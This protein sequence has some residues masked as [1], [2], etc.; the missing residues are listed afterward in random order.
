MPTRVAARDATSK[1]RA[2]AYS[3]SVLCRD[4]DA[5]GRRCLD[6]IPGPLQSD[7]AARAHYLNCMIEARGGRPFL[8]A[9][10]PAIEV[11]RQCRNLTA[12]RRIGRDSCNI[13]DELSARA[14][15][16]CLL[17]LATERFGEGKQQIIEFHSKEVAGN[18]RGV[19]VEQGGFTSGRRRVAAPFWHRSRKPAATN[20]RLPQK[21]IFQR[22]SDQPTSCPA[23]KKAQC[24]GVVR[25]GR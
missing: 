20:H 25:H 11:V 22:A 16:G 7:T 10:G 8:G 9:A 3:F 5:P 21:W 4:Q 6:P 15:V 19:K 23:C 12:P 24:C 18:P 17:Y 2:L 14:L 13:S 1:R